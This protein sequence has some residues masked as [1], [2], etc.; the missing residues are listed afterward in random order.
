[1]C[2]PSNVCGNGTLEMGEGCDDGGTMSGDGCSADCLSELGESCNDDDL[3]AVGNASC[4]SGA[5]DLTGGAPGLCVVG[6]VCGNGVLESGEGCDDG[7]A[8]AADG[9]NA[10]CLVEI[11]SP[12]N[13]EEPGRLGDG[14]C[15]T[16]VCNTGGGSPG[17]C[18]VAPGCGN[19]VLDV[20]E[21]CEDG[22]NTPGDGCN[23]AC[24]VENGSACGEDESGAV[25]DDSCASGSCD[26]SAG[27]PG[28]CVPVCGNSFLEEGEGCDD[29]NAEEGDAC[30][31][32][33]L[34]ENGNACNADETGLTGDMSCVTGLCDVSA[35][36][37]GLCRALPICGDGFTDPMEGCDDGNTEA[38]DGCNAACLVEDG[39]PCGTMGLTGGESCASMMCDTNGGEPGVC[40]MGAMGDAGPDSG[41]PPLGGG[42]AGGA[43]CSASPGSDAPM[44]VWL[45]LGLGLVFWRR[46]G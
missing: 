35:G 41:T 20:G 2:E 14:S 10:A 28:M 12:C 16:G 32:M 27:D 6:G 40:S 13:I 1:M 22:N 15:E 43:P 7:N 26:S 25:G 4:E 45:L 31:P 3:G 37:P 5:C 21:G 30:S 18:R 11:D 34:V 17:V 39:E 36:A 44:P 9:C 19:G 24:L 42:L 29:G 33:C 8:D 23:Q 46:R 38:G